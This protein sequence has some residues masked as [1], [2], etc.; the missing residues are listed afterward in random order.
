MPRVRH[1]RGLLAARER[2]LCS[3]DPATAEGVRPEVLASWRRSWRGG[4]DPGGS[5]P[6]PF[7]PPS[8]TDGRL[9]TAAEAVLGA[10]YAQLGSSS[11]SLFLSDH[12]GRLLRRWADGGA[13]N[14]SLDRIYGVPG[15]S[16][17]ESVVGTNAVGTVHETGLPALVRGGEHYQER[18]LPF[19]CAAVP[20]RHPV[21]RGLLGVLDV[22]CPERDANGVLMPWAAGLARDVE[23]WLAELA[24][25]RER[26]LLER[27]LAACAVPRHH[28]TV[29]LNE[30][31][32][33]ADPAA[34]RLLAGADQALVWEQAARAVQQRRPRTL[35]LP[36]GGREIEARC[37]PIEDGG[38]V[39]GAIVELCEPVRV[40][41]ADGHRARPGA[42]ADPALPGFAGRGRLSAED[43]RVALAARTS[44][45]PLLVRGEAG[46]GKATLLRALSADR[47]VRVLDA[48]LLPVDGV[49]A[50]TAAL[51]AARAD[52]GATVVLRHLE[53]VPARYAAAV[54]AVLDEAAGPSG[55][56]AADRVAAPSG[57]LAG[58]V[59]TGRDQ[60][61]AQ[62]G[63]IARFAHAPVEVAPLRD[64]PEDLPE[65]LTALGG[66]AGAPER[67]WSPEAV[68]ALSRA[69]WPGNVRELESVVRGVLGGGVVGDVRLTDLPGGVRDTA[70]PGRPLS[71]LHRTELDAIH[72]ALRETGGNKVEAAALLGV[73]RSTLY[74]KLR[75]F[76]TE[77]ADRA[78]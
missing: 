43:R 60:P 63:L 76:G 13:L 10:G 48:A 64:H 38:R 32:V 73:A 77:L 75:G 40:S 24:T 33:I 3:G 65:L 44:G 70:R 6:P 50:W 1:A 54:C 9:L 35:V 12:E 4:V 2:F 17:D 61:G 19:A 49:R 21:H 15:F 72:A 47:P 16:I 55:D 41:C 25:R 58:T 22:S 74:R 42:P 7:Q 8:V 56:S 59:T 36:L 37:R 68:Q 71:R 39:V 45:L 69:P 27:H 57:R 26:L 62:P 52:A 29:C 31:T 53:S 14:R 11:T 67:R 5:D 66:R 28:P 30:R 18:Y 34:S 78:Y 23:R 46:T 51:R 20:V